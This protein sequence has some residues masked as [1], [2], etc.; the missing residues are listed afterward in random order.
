MLTLSCSDCEFTADSTLSFSLPWSCQA[1][2]LEALAVDALQGVTTLKFPSNSSSA[3]PEGFLSTV[4]WTVQP[5]LSVLTD[6]TPAGLAARGYEL[7][8]GP[9]SVTHTP[10]GASL[11]PLASAVRVSVALP[12]QAAY[13]LTLLTPLTSLASLVS[14]IIGLAGILSAFRIVFAL[15]E[16][17]VERPPPVLQR[18][19]RTTS[20]VV[21]ETITVKSESTLKKVP[22]AGKPDADNVAATSDGPGVLTVRATELPGE[23]RS[24]R[25]GGLGPA[26][27]SR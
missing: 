17:A 4:S 23:V 7:L 10:L 22:P 26:P 8:S 6:L 25:G 1:L 9:S 14:S 3:G 24:P 21:S 11:L 20:G 5:M 18:L 13:S 12:L 16:G 19:W 27:V 15:T 2:Y